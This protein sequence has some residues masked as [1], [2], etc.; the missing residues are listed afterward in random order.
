MRLLLRIPLVKY[1]V[2]YILFLHLRFLLEGRVVNVCGDRE[3]VKLLLFNLIILFSIQKKFQKERSELLHNRIRHSLL[4]SHA[5]LTN[6]RTAIIAEY[7]R[8]LSDICDESSRPHEKEKEESVVVTTSEVGWIEI[9]IIN[10]LF[11]FKFLLTSSTPTPF[12]FE[13]KDGKQLQMQTRSERLICGAIDRFVRGIP[14]SALSADEVEQTVEITSN[15]REIYR[16]LPPRQVLLLLTRFANELHSDF[17]NE[18]SYE[19]TRNEEIEYVRSFESVFFYAN[20]ASTI[21][22]NIFSNIFV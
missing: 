10:S 21:S 3:N 1:R 6:S 13:L 2:L 18:K 5:R 11:Y 12:L 22:D 9:F 19:M 17:E 16:R 4:S 8:R 15:E 20:F 7:S 14:S